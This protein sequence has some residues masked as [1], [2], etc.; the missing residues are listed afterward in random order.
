MTI[1]EILRN[2][3]PKVELDNGIKCYTESDVIELMGLLSLPSSIANPVEEASKEI[4]DQAAESFFP[5]IL[6]TNHKKGKPFM[7]NWNDFTEKCRMAFKVGVDW[8]KKQDS[9]Y[10]QRRCENILK[11][12]DEYLSNE[13][14]EKGKPVHLNSIGAFSKLHK[15]IKS[16]LDSLKQQPDLL[17]GKEES[18]LYIDEVHD[19]VKQYN[20]KEISISKM[21]ELLNDKVKTHGK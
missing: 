20:K 3:P 14:Y 7:D 1:E 8:H 15:E 5:T 13:T 2:N 4:I 18:V 11:E 6:E 21:T 19:L 12:C 17:P 9:N 16:V 10:W